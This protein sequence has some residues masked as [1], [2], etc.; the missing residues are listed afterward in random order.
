MSLTT[1]VEMELR[2]AGLIDAFENDRQTWTRMALSAY[3]YTKQTVIGEPKPDDVSPHLALALLTCE[4]FLEIKGERKLV[5]KKW[6]DNFAD[7]IIARTWTEL[8]K[9]RSVDE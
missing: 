4:P 5:A 1:A 6:Y 7:L 2:N 3:E 9:R 8:T